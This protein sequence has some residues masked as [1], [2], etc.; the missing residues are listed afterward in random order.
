MDIRPAADGSYKIGNLPFGD[1]IIGKT[2]VALS[3]QSKLKEVSLSANEH[4]NL[5][6]EIGDIGKGY[7][8]YLVVLVVTEEGLPLAGTDVWLERA[9]ETVV[10]HFDGDKSK[11]LKGEP[12]EWILHARYPGYKSVRRKVAM[13]SKKEYNTQEILKPVVITMSR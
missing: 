8:G 6:I 10:P 11:S 12:G 2:A 4:K 1:Y 13:K 5:N 3:R 7:D 9:G